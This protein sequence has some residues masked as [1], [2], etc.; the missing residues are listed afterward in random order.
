VATDPVIGRGRLKRL[1][2]LDQGKV[3]RELGLRLIEGKKLVDEALAAGC[4]GEL[5]VREGAKEA[6]QGRAAGVPVHVLPAH[7]M[8]LLCDVKTP[9]EVVAIGPLPEPVSADS[10][11]RFAEKALLLDGVQDPG[12]VGALARTAAAL[13]VQGLLAGPG[14][15]DLSSPKVLRASAGSLFHLP[16]S[17]ISGPGELSGLLDV[18]GHRLVVPVVTGGEDIRNV[19][20]PPSWVLV[21]GSEAHGARVSAEGGLKVTVPMARGVESLNVAAAVAA[22]LARW[23]DPPTCARP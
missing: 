1:A 20:P 22:I 23:L 3:R 14:T 12:N 17:A 9:Q 13:G 10:V 8:E 11:L 7:D 2:R 4:V 19:T 5:F 21:A 16:Q 18:S 6:W 15:A